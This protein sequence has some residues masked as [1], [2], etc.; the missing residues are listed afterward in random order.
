[1]II[2]SISVKGSNE[3]NEDA[4]ICNEKANIYGVVD[5]AT[6]LVPYR[7]KDGETGG[8]RAS[9]IVKKYFERI[10]ISE[11]TRS[12]EE[13]M[14]GANDELGMEMEKEKIDIP[15]NENVWTTGAAVIRIRAHHIEFVQAGDCMITALYSDGTYR[16]ITRDQIAY[17][18]N[19][20][21]KE[22]VKAVKDGLRTQKEIRNR[23][24]P[25]IK[26]QKSKMNTID[27]YSVLDGSIEANLFL[28]SGKINRINLTGLIICS[29]GLFIHDE[30]DS[31]VKYD[32]MDELVK[33]ISLLGLEGFIHY[34][35]AI[36]EKD[37]ECL[38]FPRTKKSDDK[39]GIYLQFT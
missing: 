17:F 13:L 24:E 26:E 30:I 21:K 1:M 15:K 9:Q 10:S 28:E 25:L 11:N 37:P 34:L 33:K 38:R 16:V 22:W 14:I 31:S 36:E 39:T 29:D 32:P 12:L 18:D 5:G 2:E 8:R 27:G 6:S 4:L 23:V 20:T 19:N 35:N 7:S 3:W